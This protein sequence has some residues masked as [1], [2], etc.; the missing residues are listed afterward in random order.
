MAGT[1]GGLVVSPWDLEWPSPE[2]PVNAWIILQ[3]SR[4]RQLWDIFRGQGHTVVSEL[5]KLTA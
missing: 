3:D 2:H 4:E 1:S 5:T